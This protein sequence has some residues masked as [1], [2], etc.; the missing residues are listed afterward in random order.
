MDIL[1]IILLCLAMFPTLAS[2]LKWDDWWIRIFDF[3]RIQICVIQITI[4][5][6]AVWLIP[7]FSFLYIIFFALAVLSFIFQLVKIFPYTVLARQQVLRYNGTETSNSISILVSN[8]LTPNRNSDKLL[9][10][11]WKYNPDMILTLESDIW[12]QE[13]LASLEKEYP[14]TV[15]KPLD[16]LY[17]MHLYSKLPL[18]DTEITYLVDKEAPSIHGYVVLRSGEKVKFHCLHPSPPSPNERKTSTYRDAEILLIGKNVEVDK[19]PTLVFGDLN[20]VAWSRTTRLFQQLSGLLDPRIGRGFYSTFHA[21]YSLFRWPLDHI[22][23]SPDFKVIK[24]ARLSHIGSDHFPFFAH[25]YLEGH[26]GNEEEAPEALAK[27][28][29]E[30]VDE[31]IEKAEPL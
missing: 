31:K 25:L 8:V 20:D 22:F 17:G 4:L 27:E 7:N 10:L 18:M 30:W 24:I 21:D 29:E 3:P 26:S 16:N 15:K 19:E 6:T 13:Q 2:L 23:I 28:E 1:A 12:W 9:D 5:I 14:Y 11:V